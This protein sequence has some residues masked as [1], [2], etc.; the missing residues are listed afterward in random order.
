MWFDIIRKEIVNMEVVKDIIHHL[1]GVFY[2]T[3]NIPK[4]I[5]N[6]KFNDAR[7]KYNYLRNN[8]YVL[9]YDY[10]EERNLPRV[11]ELSEYI[12]KINLILIELT[13]WYNSVPRETKRK[14]RN[15]FREINK[16]LNAAKSLFLDSDF[17]FEP[18]LSGPGGFLG[19]YYPRKDTSTVNLPA[20]AKQAKEEEKLI[21]VISDT[22]SH[23][24]GHQASRN[25]NSDFRLDPFFE[26]MLA[27][28]VQYPN[29]KQKAFK[30]WLEH[31]RVIE[32]VER[33]GPN[34]HRRK[35]VYDE[36]K[37]A[38]K[39]GV[40]GKRNEKLYTKI[41]LA[42]HNAVG[43]GRNPGETYTYYN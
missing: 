25:I 24:F 1:D 41:M 6:S 43:P 29:D 39:S 10:Y 30:R 35:E 18:K 32:A 23:E 27:Y 17:E 20:A 14:S 13:E 7:S 3:K 11:N 36:I 40:I 15:L 42:L 2:Y 22:L 37:N 16:E 31:P 38:V 33:G 34:R 21:E 5:K 26:E 19:R 8:M 12:L 9:E 28:L 4:K